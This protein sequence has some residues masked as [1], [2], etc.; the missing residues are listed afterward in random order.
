M[1][2]VQKT[3]DVDYYWCSAQCY[4]QWLCTM[5]LH[6]EQY[7]KDRIVQRLKHI[8]TVHRRAAWVSDFKDFGTS[9]FRHRI[10]DL[11]KEKI[12]GY[13]CNGEAC[14]PAKY[15]LIE[16]TAQLPPIDPSY[17]FL[18]KKEHNV[19]LPIS[20]QEILATTKFGTLSMHNIRLTF[21]MPGL[22]KALVYTTGLE[23]H[24]SNHTRL[25]PPFKLTPDRS[26][27][28]LCYPD[29]A[30]VQIS[31][32]NNPIALNNNDVSDL[33]DMVAHAHGRL[34]SRIDNNHTIPHFD[35]WIMRS[36][37]VGQDSVTRYEG[38]R[39]RVSFKELRNGIYY[40]F[41]THGNKNKGYVHRIE[42][43]EQPNTSI[44]EALQSYQAEA[45]SLL[46]KAHKE[47]T[48]KEKTNALIKVLEAH[49]KPI[50][51]QRRMTATWWA[52]DGMT[53]E[54]LERMIRDT[55]RQ[56]KQQG[57]EQ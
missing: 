9:S 8:H 41:Y 17:P 49:H 15:V 28:I 20:L 19:Q 44:T 40:Q 54:E 27:T 11:I 57:S 38:D 33:Y 53:H 22:Q 52:K 2:T 12:V 48:L 5:G 24:N 4:A 36:I 3:P 37:E 14:K 6:N 31:C 13:P 35:Q 42:R 43:K 34:S 26:Y 55:E 47:Q 39:Y 46:T 21:D 1:T 25:F 23:Y 30:Q 29:S 56:L 45:A 16:Y 7:D 32:T 18:L 50:D 10:A 51:S